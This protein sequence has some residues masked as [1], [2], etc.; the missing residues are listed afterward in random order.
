[1]VPA[2][3]PRA[4]EESGVALN[5]VFTGDDEIQLIN[6]QPTYLEGR[7]GIELAYQD[8]DGHTVTY[9]DR[10]GRQRWSCPSAAACRSTAGARWCGRKAASA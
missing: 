7:R 2:V 1:M 9:L 5:W 4:M 10:A 3:L 8:A 6:A